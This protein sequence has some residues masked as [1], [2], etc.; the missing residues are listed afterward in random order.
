[1]LCPHVLST[2]NA[3]WIMWSSKRP[4]KALQNSEI[5]FPTTNARRTSRGMNPQFVQELMTSF[6]LCWILAFGLRYA[7]IHGNFYMCFKMDIRSLGKG[8][9]KTETMVWDWKSSLETLLDDK[10]VEDSW[11]SRWMWRGS[12]Y[13]SC[14]HFCDSDYIMQKL[15]G[16]YVYDVITKSWPMC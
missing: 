5:I 6:Q 10:L 8:L 15:R 4:C 14:V 7:R 11:Q 16:L 3:T 1:M 2:G 9:L 12:A 13:H